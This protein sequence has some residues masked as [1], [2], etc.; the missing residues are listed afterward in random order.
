MSIDG[1]PWFAVEVK[2]NDTAL[3]PQLL[4]FKER[5]AIPYVYQVVKK[6]PL[7]GLKRRTNHLC[8]KVSVRSCIDH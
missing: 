5:V 3:S 7:T 6:A 1:K 4:Y 8:G 2:L